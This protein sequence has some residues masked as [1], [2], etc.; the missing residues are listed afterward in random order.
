MEYK[1]IKIIGPNKNKVRFVDNIPVISFQ[2]SSQPPQ[3]WIKLFDRISRTRVHS[4]KPRLTVTGDYMEFL[5]SGDTSELQQ[6]LD[7]VNKDIAETNMEYKKILVAEQQQNADAKK[8]KETIGQEIKDSLD[9]LK[10]E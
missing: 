6:I 10:Y 2:L 7:L 4:L 8:K 3:I 5:S 9:G 1:D